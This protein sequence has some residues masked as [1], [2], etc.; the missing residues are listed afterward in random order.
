MS[1]IEQSVVGIDFKHAE[2]MDG[3][4]NLSDEY[5][6]DLAIRNAVV[7]ASRTIEIARRVLENLGFPGLHGV[8]NQCA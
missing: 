5:H 8:P 6:C 2:C 4:R 1:V 7:E 3:L